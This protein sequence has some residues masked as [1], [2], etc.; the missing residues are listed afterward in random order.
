MRRVSRPVR[1]LIILALTFGQGFC[2]GFGPPR[3]AARDLDDSAL[4][5]HQVGLMARVASPPVGSAAALLVDVATRT[6]LFAKN[7]ETR[8]A[9]AST[10]KMVT[11][12]VAL[13]R[14]DLG[15]EV[16]VRSEDLAI[17]SFAGLLGG[18]V[19]KLEDLLYALLLSSDN[20]AALVI[21]RHIAGS[22]TAFVALMNEQVARWGLRDTHFVNPHGFDDPE[23]YSTA[24]DLAEIALRCLEN[25]VFARIV[26]TREHQVGWRTLVNLNQLLGSYEGAQGVKTGTTDQAGQCLVSL[27]LRPG[28]KA[29]CVIL[30]SPDR[31]QDSR[32]LLDYYFAHFRVLA[33]RLGP[34]GLNRIREPD[35]HDLVLVADERPQVL[36]P[37]WQLPWLR[38]QRVCTGMG[39]W[40]PGVRAGTARFHL[41]N[42]VL[43]EVPLYV[44]AP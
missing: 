15:D 14:G 22:E 1:L 43:A 23:H 33:L 29:L 36:L 44:T 16:T 40:E 30:G 32:L 3:L 10:T 26:S 8:L 18:E 31:Y 5:P 27:V 35:G 11:A 39:P 34:K 4:W 25:P 21:A 7:A 41:G 12:L 38:V 2:L 28:G 17:G 13:E 20:A 24:A 42:A 9:P 6:R 37:Q 19:W